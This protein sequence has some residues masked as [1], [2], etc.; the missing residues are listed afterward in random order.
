MTPLRATTQFDSIN[1]AD[2]LVEAEAGDGGF[3]P[4]DAGAGDG[5]RRHSAVHDTQRFSKDDAGPIDIFEPMRG[6][7]D[8]E[9]GG[10]DFGQEMG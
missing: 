3:V 4:S 6:R 10:T 8:A 1:D 5:R 2:L 7:T 9:Q